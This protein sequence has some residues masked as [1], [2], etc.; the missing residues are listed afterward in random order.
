M[1]T[2][3]H[4]VF[5]YAPQDQD[6]YKALETHLAL[7]ERQGYVTRWTSRMLGPGVAREAET[8]RALDRADLIV[9]L[10]SADFL[11]S[12]QIFDTDLKRALARRAERP[13]DVMG[14]LLRPCDWR[15][16]DLAAVDMEP[17]NED[18]IAVPV[19]A[20]PNPDVPYTRIAEKIRAH[21]AHRV[22][23]LSLNPPMAHPA[24]APLG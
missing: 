1:P 2:P 4:V 14:V 17:R 16:G 13:D 3:I 6:H 8:E 24:P 20:W 21:A 11:A 7:L 22:G 19:T 9:L 18:G 10:V 5:C 12:D 15:H 23:S